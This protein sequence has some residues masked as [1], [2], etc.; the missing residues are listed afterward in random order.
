MTHETFIV[1][2]DYHGQHG[3]RDTLAALERHIKELKPKHR[4]CLGDMFDMACLRKGA[5]SQDGESWEGLLQD[6]TAG[7][8]AL[9]RL[10]PTVFLNGNH[11]Y[12]LYQAAEEAASG[13]VRE[14]CQD[15]VNK[16]EKYLRKMGCKV[17]P[18]HYDQGVHRIGSVAF[19]HGYTANVAAVKQHAEIYAD[20]GGAVVMGHIHR[21]EAVQAVR[22]GGAKGYSYGCLADIPKLTYA[23]LRPATM[24]WENGWVF[25]IVG[26]GKKNFKIWQAEK[27][28]GKWIL[29][30]NLTEL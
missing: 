11:E 7:Y 20:P 24:R 26:K 8:M 30:T 2:G 1:F 10:R 28:A 17:Y 4:I 21:I 14:Y 29:P 18:Y 3:C 19:V 27:T 15:G 23:A 13:I 9:E 25:G 6:Q 5:R 16:L 12:R 22:H